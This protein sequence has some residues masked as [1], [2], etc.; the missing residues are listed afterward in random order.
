MVTRYRTPERFLFNASSPDGRTV[1]VSE[2]SNVLRALDAR[3]GEQLWVRD[4]PGGIGAVA[5]SPDGAAVAV[6]T[7]GGDNTAIGIS[8]LDP[9]DGHVLHRLPFTRVIDFVGPELR[10]GLWYGGGWT[11]DHRW[12]FATESHVLVSD[13]RGRM[14]AAVEWPRPVF[15]TQSLRVWPDG[16]VSTGPSEVGPGVVIDL[17]APAAPGRT[18]DGMVLGVSPDGTRL[19]EVR[20]DDRGS[21]VQVLDARSLAPRSERWPVDGTVRWASFSRT[22]TPSRWPSRRRSWFGTRRAPGRWRRFAATAGA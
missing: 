10:G 18:T 13:R 16:H 14:L 11:R 7:Y 17:E 3:T 15:D 6:G 22:A 5:P 19:V 8:L 21:S 20:E 12:V 9:A 2:N 4:L 1:F